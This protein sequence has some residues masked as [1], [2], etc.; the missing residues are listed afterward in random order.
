MC[1]QETKEKSIRVAFWSAVLEGAQ[2]GQEDEQLQILQFPR[3]DSDLCDIYRLY[4]KPS[5]TE[6][7]AARIHCLILSKN[8][9]DKRTSQQ[10]WIMQHEIVLSA[11]M[12]RFLDTESTI[13]V[14]LKACT[15]PRNLSSIVAWCQTTRSI[16]SLWIAWKWR[17][18]EVRKNHEKH[19][20]CSNTSI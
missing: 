2:W 9:E 8:T 14:Y 18:G 15:S 4:S 19:V 20:T 12:I 16:R 6:S 1:W 7:K 17:N 13:Y 11:W 3:V 5:C 10:L